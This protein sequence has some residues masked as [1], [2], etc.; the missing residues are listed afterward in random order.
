MS[1]RGAVALRGGGRAGDLAVE[2]LTERNAD[3]WV[4]LFDACGCAC[5]CRYWH[6]EGTK[7]QWLARSFEAV[8]QNADEQLALLRA[9]AIE[10]RGLLAMRGK[11]AV[12]W[13]KLAPRA[14]LPKLRNQRA[15]RAVDL[16]PDE[17]I[18]S[19]GCFLVRPAERRRGVARALLV[20]APEWAR[21]WG[22]CAIEA[23]P[24]RVTYA[25]HD[26]EAWMGPESV[27]VEQCWSAVHDVAPYPVYR[28]AL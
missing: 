22:A 5:F 15:Y 14:R 8:T 13:M 6:F 4:A 11:D 19:V 16:G 3:A 9:G 24:H 21:A 20:A 7:E 27:F 10:A 28:K 23:Y 12:G 1:G 26:E 17:G 25:L 18:W 2:P